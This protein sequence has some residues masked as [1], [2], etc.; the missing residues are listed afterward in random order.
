MPEPSGP[1]DLLA[2]VRIT[3]AG[4]WRETRAVTDEIAPVDG[5]PV[6]DVKPAQG[7]GAV[8]DEPD[9]RPPQWRPEHGDSAGALTWFYL[10][11]W[12]VGD[13]AH[14]IVRILVETRN[15]RTRRP[16]FGHLYFRG[17]YDGVD[18]EYRLNGS[19]HVPRDHTID[20][21]VYAWNPVQNRIRFAHTGFANRHV[22]TVPL[23]KY[24][25]WTDHPHGHN[26]I[27]GLP[28]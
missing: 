25:R 15:L 17:L 8:I 1:W 14:A 24:W 7:D 18:M 22:A 11:R 21:H 5:D 4:R 19:R 2:D 12:T 9:P 16:A 13:E 10:K 27:A 3:A 20:R 28:V 26:P 6:A 23:G